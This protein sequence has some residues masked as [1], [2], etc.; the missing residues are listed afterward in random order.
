MRDLALIL[1][2]SIFSCPL[3]RWTVDLLSSSVLVFGPGC[4]DSGA[5]GWK[6]GMMEFTKPAW[7]R[8]GATDALRGETEIGRI[9]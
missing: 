4:K 1:H 6:Q 7:V 3:T 5:V 2:S 9:I 8:G